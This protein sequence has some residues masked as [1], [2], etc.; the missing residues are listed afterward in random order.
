MKAS[1]TTNLEER[2]RLVSLFAFER[3]ARALFGGLALIWCIASL[4]FPFGWDQGIMASVG[5]AI[6]RGGMP[7]RD[8]WEVKGPLAYYIFAAAEAVLGAHMWSIRVFDVLLLL[9]ACAALARMVGRLTSPVTGVWIAIAF[10]FWYASLS[11]FFVSQPDGWVALIMILA[12]EP[13]VGKSERAG[14]G[15]LAWCALMTGCCALIKPFYAAFALVPASFV[16][17]APEPRSRKAIAIAFIGAMTMLPV[18]L[19]LAW[20]A[21]RGAWASWMEVQFVY[22]PAYADGSLLQLGV[23]ARKV[24]RYLWI[25]R[26]ASPTGSVAVVLPAIGY[27]VYI[28]WRESRQVA[29]MMAAWLGVALFCL[30]IQGKFFVYQWIP[31]FPPFAV[32]S[33]VGLWRIANS[34][35]DRA[36]SGFALAIVSAALFFS[37]T[38]VKPGVDVLR[39][40]QLMTGATNS[41]AY[42]QRYVAWRY[43]AGDNM[44]A[45]NYIR[46][47]T[48]DSDNVA[49]FGND[50]TI[51][52][53]SGRAN[54]T[55]FLMGMPLTS[56]GVDEL[57]AAYRQEY[58]AGLRMQP[59]IYFVVGQPYDTADK[60]A[61][62]RQFPELQ[63]FLQVRYSLESQIGF[64]D[65]YRLRE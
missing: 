17:F 23:L 40:L 32:L 52:F 30:A 53:L 1:M 22:I 55:R 24:F 18:V 25:D 11:W 10:V 35:T 44:A 46:E 29:A 14:F 4:W 3:I 26:T 8:A 41:P 9:V 57:R 56:S 49:V 58:M 16:V 59:P 21:Y 51:N 20:F 37:Q 12:I 50:A 6:V 43:V 34:T 13:L 36:S 65:L 64:L 28:L 7:Y 47:R 45:A 5:S 33:G 60:A 2:A 61:V 48:R 42:Y 54:P 31:T 62:L 15:V 38:V 39:W 19:T 27:A 63:D